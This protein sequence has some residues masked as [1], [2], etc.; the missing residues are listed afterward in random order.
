MASQNS[1]GSKC[2]MTHAVV[3]LRNSKKS[4]AM[5]RI[6]FTYVAM[7][8]FFCMS[9]V[10]VCAYFCVHVGSVISWSSAKEERSH[11]RSHSP[12]C[13]SNEPP[14]KKSKTE[15]YIVSPT[16][17]LLLEEEETITKEDVADNLQCT[18][19]GDVSQNEVNPPVE[20]LPIIAKLMYL[21]NHT[22]HFDDKEITLL[23][24]ELTSVEIDQVCNHV[25]SC[26]VCNNQS[27]VVVQHIII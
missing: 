16:S 21:C 8:M 4:S 24:E 9:T 15:E 3:F 17:P 13:L 1:N 6:Y 27:C 11:K 23:W 14:L 20:I 7:L 22:T 25:K 5:S 19:K 10:Y 18:N 2:Q 12:I 26:Q